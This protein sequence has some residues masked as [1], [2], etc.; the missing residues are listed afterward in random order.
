MLQL[1]TP[2]RRLLLICCATLIYV[3]L[4]ADDVKK[5]FLYG[6]THPALALWVQ[7]S[8]STLT[9]LI[10][11]AV[12][13]LVWLYARE[14]MAAGLLFGFSCSMMIVFVVQTGALYNDR[15]LILLS[16][17]GASAAIPLLVMLLFFFPRNYFHYLREAKIQHQE[18]A[19]LYTLLL[20]CARIYTGVLL[21][22]AVGSIGSIVLFFFFPL[23]RPQW[24]VNVIDI[25][26]ILGL[27]SAIFITIA[28]YVQNSSLRER[29]QL[30]LFVVGVV[31]TLA[32][33][34][35]L[36]IIPTV[37]H[38]SASYMVDAQFSTLSFII[39]PLSLGY[40]VL[41]YQVLVFDTYIR[42]ACVWLMGC[43]GLMSLIFLVIMVTSQVVLVAPTVYGVIVT[44]VTAL[45]APLVWEL[46]KIITERLF[47]SEALHYRRLMD[48]PSRLAD[49]TLELHETV[50]LCMVAFMQVF[51]TTAVCFFM[52]EE[53]SGY[54]RL[55][56][57]LQHEAYAPNDAERSRLMASLVRAFGETSMPEQQD[58]FALHH[59]FVVQVMAAQHPFLL[60]EVMAHGKEV[61]ARAGLRR[62]INMATSGEED[63]LIA[64]IRVQGKVIGVV[65]LGERGD[66]QAYAGPDFETV[67]LLLSR[68]A[69][70]LETARLYRK[71]RQHADLLN[72]L[73][74]TD[75]MPSD[76]FQ[77]ANDVAYSY[78]ALVAEA[79]MAV[80][81]I[82]LYDEQHSYWNRVALCGVGTPLMERE[83]LQLNQV[84][85]WSSCFYEG[86]DSWQCSSVAMPACLERTPAFPF[87]WL[88]MHK[89]SKRLGVLTL[90][91]Q[92]PHIFTG[93]ERRVL[94][95]FANQCAAAL[96]NAR[97]AL[98]LQTAYERQKELDAL[99][100]QFIVIT[101]HELRTPLTAVQGYIELLEQYGETLNG[102]ERILFT[103]KAHRGC[104]ELV[105]M[106]ENIMDASRVRVE[107][108]NINLEE[109]PLAE[110]VEH[111][112]EILGALLKSEQRTV[113]VNIATDLNVLADHL[114]LRQVLLNLLSN[115]R[116]Y[117]S[118]STPLEITARREGQFVVIA[119]RDYGS[120]IAV[121]DQARLFERFVRLERDMNS[122]VRGAGLGLYICKQ[123]VEAMGGHIWVES[124]GRGGE[125]STF[126]F[127]LPYAA[128]RET[129]PVAPTGD[130]TTFPATLG[131]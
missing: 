53:E 52:L 119:I 112:L 114:R 42:R 83:T 97:N 98:E 82:W 31:L 67:E 126:S 61:R 124:S 46:A 100:D 64:P 11:L 29:Q 90:A 129:A 113:E 26:Q 45:L 9:S 103:R 66:K 7:F 76:V 44:T 63:M 71:A 60:S 99:K 104:D 118:V 101:S 3:L 20:Q 50:R 12:G 125:G 38:F 77:V 36:T 35:L 91:Y 80:A 43:I 54:Y 84:G 116:K 120:G 34:L 65:V 56:P 1:K 87:A 17:I 10:F 21:L 81:E 37:L 62:Y 123:L 115:A 94:E 109:L 110:P 117:S 72:K 121:A 86:E 127:T 32:P 13:A 92:R 102:E 18:Q 5:T 4:V 131:A 75:S 122:P 27:A 8:T 105:L 40:S 130:A 89:G 14:R 68:F 74:A 69:S 28:I 48:A 30:R 24:L 70:L 95:M 16:S 6:L 59:P 41:R 39:F 57:E 19:Q 96:E 15:F 93:E 22:F 49:T 25:Y 73:Y 128:R 47:F 55:C 107:A 33:F 108:Q 111:V 51:E 2:V 85:D 88:P 106:V 58:W 23:S 79:V 78:A